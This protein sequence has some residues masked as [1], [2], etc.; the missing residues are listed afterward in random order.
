MVHSLLSTWTLYND[1]LSTQV[2]KEGL[3]M[4]H[5][6]QLCMLKSSSKVSVSHAHVCIEEILLSQQCI[7]VSM[8]TDFL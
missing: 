1:E 5:I 8:Y 7:G 4:E 6:D 3:L 2:V